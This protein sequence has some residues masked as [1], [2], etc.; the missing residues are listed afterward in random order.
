M[1]IEARPIV[2]LNR[3]VR[4]QVENL[5]VLLRACLTKTPIEELYKYLVSLPR[6]LALDNQGLAKAASPEDF[7]LLAPKGLHRENLKK[8][9]EIY[10]D[11]P[12]PFF[13]EAALDRGYF[14]GLVARME[15]LPR[16]DREI[17]EP[18]VYQ[19]VDIFHLML[20]A[21]GKFYY[22]L[23][24]DMLLPLHVGGTRIPLLLFTAMLSDIDLYTSVER[25]VERV[26]DAV[27]F[28]QGF[29][30]GLMTVDAS[31]L[32]SF[33]WKRFFRFA[34]LAFRK[35][36]VGLGAIMGYSGLRRVEVAN[37]ITISEGIHGGMAAETIRGRLIPR[38]VF[39]EGMK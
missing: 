20:V 33:A 12:R 18:M 26:F 22:N 1:Q 4:F 28:R 10:H 32:E 36:N 7:V 17:I 31:T 35:G 27:S 14:Q 29:N 30:D 23:T 9:L 13:F 21:R 5:K 25:A 15:G 34:N 39:T 38:T 37:L 19:E 16:E 2:Q 24:P 8:A 11:Y 3:V 6:E